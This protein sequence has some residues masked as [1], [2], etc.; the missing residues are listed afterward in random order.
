MAKTIKRSE[1]AI[2]SRQ[3]AEPKLR[4]TIPPDTARAPW[5]AGQDVAVIFA[6]PSGI[7]RRVSRGATELLGIDEEHAVG[8]ILGSLLDFDDPKEFAAA[9]VRAGRGEEASLPLILNAP[10]GRA[11]EGRALLLPAAGA[12]GDHGEIL[13]VLSDESRKF[14]LERRLHQLQRTEHTTQVVLGLVHDLNNVFMVLQ[15]FG[16][17]VDQEGASSMVSED[18][19]MIARAV[20]HGHSLT[21]RL[22]SLGSGV[23]SRCVVVDLNEVV[24]DAVGIIGRLVGGG[25][26]VVLR[27][28]PSTLPVEVSPGPIEQMLLNLAINARD[29][30]EGRGRLTIALDTMILTAMAPSEPLEPGAYASI[31]V[32]DSGPGVPEAIRE[33]IFEPFF[34]TKSRERGTGLGLCSVTETVR[35]LRGRVTLES[36]RE[37]GARFRILIPLASRQSGVRRC[38]RTI[39]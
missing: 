26:D 17:L 38:G 34:T 18:W 8:R 2:P 13:L 29:A 1:L 30:M 24:S 5:D 31:L 7:V 6:S 33:R 16:A 11:I 32:A 23:A 37:P 28:G 19:R 4:D 15:T 22:L 9:W 12:I 36:S 35:E 10:D 27:R 3:P 14:D 21:D 39:A 25:I 20:R